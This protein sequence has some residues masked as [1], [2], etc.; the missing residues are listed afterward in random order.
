[1]RNGLAVEYLRHVA[2]LEVAV[3]PSHTDCHYGQREA[4]P[5]ATLSIGGQVERARR[6]LTISSRRAAPARNA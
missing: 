4:T 2:G 5:W 3:D 1:M 6:F